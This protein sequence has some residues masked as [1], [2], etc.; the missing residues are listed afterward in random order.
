MDADA[1]VKVARDGDVAIVTMGNPPVN[2]LRHALRVGLVAAFQELA[3]D[4]AVRAVVLT[5][6]TRAFCGGAD[7]TEFGRP[8]A[9]PVPRALI[10]MIEDMRVPVVAAISGVALG[11]GLELALGCHYRV[12][13]DGA[14]VGLP[15]VK[16]GILPGAGGTQRLPRVVGI[17]RALQAIVL[18][19]PFTLEEALA[20][21]LIDARM[22][23]PFPGAAVA[24]ARRIA[25]ESAGRALPRVRTRDERLIEG[26][27]DP[28]MIDRLAAPLLKR[29]RGRAAPRNCVEAVRAAV[30][31]PFEQGLAEEARLFQ[32]LVNG[33]ESRAQ[34]YMFFAE[35]EALKVPDMPRDTPARPVARAI[36][37]GAGTMGG[38]IAM[39]FANAGIP[40]TIIDTDDAALSR[41]MDR[42][43][44][45]Y[46]VAVKRGSLDQASMDERLARFERS[47]DFGAVA[48]GDI[49]IEAVF[50]DL[51]LKERV[52]ADL[53]RH[54]RPGA[55]LASN[56]S[57]LDID[58]MAAVTA[59][60]E[61]VLG[62]HFFSPANVMKLLEVVRAKR[63]SFQ[64][65]ATAL[66]VGRAIGKQCAVVG[67]CDGFV[68]NRMLA[69]RTAQAE[70]LLL[71]GALP[72]D[73][74]AAVRGFG[75]PMGPFAMGDL[76]GLDVGWRIRQHR[77]TKAAIA[78]A[79]CEAGRFGQKTRA[80][81]YRYEEDGRVPLPDPE[82]ERIIV[83]ASEARQIKRRAIGADEIV[84]RMVYP[85]VNEA[86]R[87]L[88][89]GIA[90]RASDIDVIWVH[91]YG[92]PVWRGGP[93][94]FADQTGL[95]RVAERLAAYADATGEESLRPAPLLAR[96]ARD[97]GTFGAL[98]P[99]EAAA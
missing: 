97:G 36:V 52:F 41:G 93:M 88:S 61:D 1:L 79:L 82:V 81:Y 92:W 18:G 48:T 6:S 19:E 72:Q 2:A 62:M 10:P 55:L 38:G 35:R 13:W 67:V 33:E 60:P 70:R 80:G 45:N 5:G 3:E 46:A 42:V 64:A 31:L 68:G 90:T 77:G 57:T 65:L 12:A 98:K 44:G 59:R 86:A 95:S 73:V 56:T 15:E 20:A 43:A 32:E 49:V 26:R 78:D 8:R 87:I 50:E 25:D 47:T 99:G 74:D 23:G 85:M 66:A 11:G 89:E 17:A 91:G 14:R 58:R 94:F 34:R 16:L 7:I 30:M 51:A 39:C 54:A 22:E 84:E 21:G 76:A 69:R 28:G 63:T 96:L 53:D 83:A 75:F 40:V 29:A 24:Y 37:L 4:K 9:E 71:E 27:A